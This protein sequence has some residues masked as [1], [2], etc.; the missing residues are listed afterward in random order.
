MGQEGKKDA[1]S[2]ETKKT[3]LAAGAANVVIAVTKLVAGL[4]AGSSSMLAEAAHSVA[5]TL[6]QAF[7]LASLRRSARPADSAHP[8]GYGQERYFWSL[9]AAI[10][11]FV[12]GAG[13]SITEGVYAIVSPGEH[14]DPTVAFV[15]LGVACLAEGASLVRAVYQ[16]RKEAAERERGLMEHAQKTPDLTLKATLFE[17]SAAV[18]GLVIAAAGLTLRELTGSSLWDGAG[19]IAIGV[20]LIGVAWKLGTNSMTLLIG[21]SVDRETQQRIRAEIEATDGVDQVL[22]LQTMHLGPD[23]VLVASRI[24]FSDGISAGDA[25]QIAG[26]IDKRLQERIDVVRHVFLDPT[27]GSVSRTE[28][29][30]RSTT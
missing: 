22:E 28:P 29:G 4:L 16:T 30:C 27:A 10:G 7:L 19:S 17:D 12:A 26:E 15:V 8:F 9:L 24:C 18:I 6:N 5:D 2:D 20:L 23:E 1:K 11:I 3:V 14:G 21:R 25:E 13:F